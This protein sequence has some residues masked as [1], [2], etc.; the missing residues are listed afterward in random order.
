M[1]SYDV[2]LIGGGPANI[3][4]AS[5]LINNGLKVALFEQNSQ[6]GKKFLVAGKSGLNLS[7]DFSYTDF[8][9]G[10][11]RDKDFINHFLKDFTPQDQRHFFETVLG[12]ETYVGSAGK[13]FPKESAVYFLKTWLSYLKNN[14]LKI[15]THHQW[16]SGAEH[17]HQIINLRTK[18]VL[19]VS[20]L[21]T[22]FGLG[23][24][25]WRETGSNALWKSNFENLGVNIIPFLPSNSGIICD[26]DDFIFEKWNGH[27]IKNCTLR[28][29][30]E[31][32]TG[33]IRIGNGQL[34][35]SPIYHLNHTIRCALEKGDVEVYLDFKP[36]WTQEHLEKKWNSK[37]SISKNLKALKISPIFSSLYKCLDTTLNPNLLIKN[38]P[39]KVIK[40]EE[41]DKAISTI[42]GVD[43]QNTHKDLS[44]KS[45]HYWFV[46]GEMLDWDAPTGGYLLTACFAMGKKISEC[47]LENKK[48]LNSYNNNSL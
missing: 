29:L 15:F 48:D 9:N 27:F 14:G 33:E 36:Q 11:Y 20:S 46:N 7:M 25:S 41:L 44:L 3:M 30:T 28:C 13:V 1:H 21:Y 4:A 43:I 39:I 12:V 38:Y 16:L 31:E 6:L 35:G 19:T 37:Y 34:E 45:N 8:I 23:G 40:F 32:F 22:I 10:Y 18:E 24:N 17:K 47:I 5:F 26:L 2:I 42:G